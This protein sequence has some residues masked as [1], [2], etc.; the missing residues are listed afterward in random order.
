MSRRYRDF[1]RTGQTLAEMAIVLPVLCLGIFTAVQ[2]CRYGINMLESQRMAQLN[3]KRLTAE[4][5]PASRNHH[6]FHSLKGVTTTPGVGFRRRVAVPWRAHHG[7]RTLQ[8]RGWIAQAEVESQLL[9]SGGWTKTLPRL[10]QSAIAWTYLEPE[11]PR[12]N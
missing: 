12:E 2:T 8:T 1:S 5:F 7:F 4:D 3:A 6:L 9:P 10:R 11:V